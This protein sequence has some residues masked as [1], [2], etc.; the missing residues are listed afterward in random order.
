MAE[1]KFCNIW[2]RVLFPNLWYSLPDLPFGDVQ[3]VEQFETFHINN[4]D[5]GYL[6][7][8]IAGATTAITS[9]PD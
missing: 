9:R 2:A 8:Y 5:R 6:I 1:E 3:S 4:T 7:C